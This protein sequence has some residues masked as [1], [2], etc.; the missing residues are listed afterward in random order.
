MIIQKAAYEILKEKGYPLSYKEI[1]RIA[2]VRGVVTSTARDPT[3]SLGATILKNIKDGIYNEPK[4]CFTRDKSGRRLISLPEWEGKD[5]DKIVPPEPPRTVEVDDETAKTIELA[6]VAGVGKNESE[7]VRCLI[8]A[9]FKALANEIN[10]GLS[11]RLNEL[12]SG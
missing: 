9:G 4:L 6:R 2:L 7:T 12:K 5:K 10:S 8:R 3:S 11:K 1:A